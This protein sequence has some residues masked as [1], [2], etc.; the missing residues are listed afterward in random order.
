M[1]RAARATTGSVR[2]AVFLAGPPPTCRP[3]AVL[4]SPVAARR[5][6]GAAARRAA[7]AAAPTALSKRALLGG[8]AASG[9]W[10]SSRGLATAATM[11]AEQVELADALTACLKLLVLGAVWAATVTRGRPPGAEAAAQQVL[12]FRPRPA[13]PAA[14]NPDLS[15]ALGMAQR[16]PNGSTALWRGA[17]R[18]PWGVPAL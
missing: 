6:A 12:L 8:L 2:G 18:L 16:Q 13:L 15:Q 9:L 17:R 11:T 7:A 3:A 14:W 10:L 4:R 1:Q 5:S